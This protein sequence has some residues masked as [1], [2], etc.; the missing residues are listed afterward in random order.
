MCPK[1]HSKQ[2]QHLAQGPLMEVTTSRNTAEEKG[3]MLQDGGGGGGSVHL[4]CRQPAKAKGI[5]N[6][7]SGF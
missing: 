5:I 4:G 3:H 2:L 1:D 7:I 6:F